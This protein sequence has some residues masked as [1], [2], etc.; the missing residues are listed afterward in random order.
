MLAA[1]MALTAPGCV[2]MPLN[3]PSPPAPSRPGTPP[4]GV[5]TAVH[6]GVN[7][8]RT[9]LGLP[10]LALDPTLSALAREHSAAMA[11]G[12]VAFGHDGFERRADAA[13]GRIGVTQM[14]ENVAM[15]N[16]PPATAADRV[17]RGWI[18]SPG[19]RRNLEG[20]YTL[21]GVGAAS[22]GAGEIF[23]TQLYASP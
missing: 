6:D 21:S 23:V 4:A 16:F 22:N 14:A 13:L 10:A 17:V 2:P 9:S 20:R 7:R 18:A 3:L 8:H 5:E 1:V 15:N 19:H 11:A 12:T